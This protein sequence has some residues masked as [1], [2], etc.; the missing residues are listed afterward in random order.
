MKEYIERKA[1]LD[2][3]GEYLGY[4]IRERVNAVPAA[5]VVPRNAYNAIRWERDMMEKQLADIGKTLGQNMDDVHSMSECT[6]CRETT[7]QVIDDIKHAYA[8][9]YKSFHPIVTGSWKFDP[10]CGD[11]ECLVCGY[12]SMEH[13]RYCTFCGAKMSGGTNGSNNNSESSNQG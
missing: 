1:V 8:E 6:K 10:L 4:V 11:W 7:N 12:H 2:S 9:K 13:G 5:D 3:I